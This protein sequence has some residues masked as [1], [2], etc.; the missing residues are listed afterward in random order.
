MDFKRHHGQSNNKLMEYKHKI[1]RESETKIVIKIFYESC[2]S[3][4]F[5][6]SLTSLL[7]RVVIAYH[8]KQ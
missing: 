8:S 6:L 2:K 4:L 5:K 7:S 3:N 1:L